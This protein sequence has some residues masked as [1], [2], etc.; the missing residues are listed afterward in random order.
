ME[1]RSRGK[2]VRDVE[3]LWETEVEQEIGKG[4]KVDR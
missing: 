1:R 3:S 4:D 2:G